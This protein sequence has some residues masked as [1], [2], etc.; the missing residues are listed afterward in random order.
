MLAPTTGAE[1]ILCIPSGP[2]E[3]TEKAMIFQ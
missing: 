1:C 2:K 3:L